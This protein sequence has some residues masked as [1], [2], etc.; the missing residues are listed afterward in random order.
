M[1]P[2]DLVLDGT[3]AQLQR[4]IF[5]QGQVIDHLRRENAALK[6]HLELSSQP[7]DD[8]EAT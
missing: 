6:A 8:V 1:N 3:L 7:Q 2:E 4:L 5:V